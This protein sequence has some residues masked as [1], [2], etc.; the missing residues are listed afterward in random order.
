[1]NPHGI[2]EQPNVDC[3]HLQQKVILPTQSIKGEESPS[4]LAGEE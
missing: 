1:M 3:T 4:K 2:W